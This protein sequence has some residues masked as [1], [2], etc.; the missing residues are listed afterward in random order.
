MKALAKANLKAEERSK[1]TEAVKAERDA[2]QTK[3]RIPWS[4]P[5]R[6]ALLEYIDAVSANRQTLSQSFDRAIDFYKKKMDEG[7]AKEYLDAKRT[8][9]QPRVVA[10]WNYTWLPGKTHRREML[11]DMAFRG[12]EGSW[13]VEKNVVIVKGPDPRLKG[14]HWVDTFETAPDGKTMSGKN[15]LGHKK[16]AKLVEGE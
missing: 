7:K 1:L 3:G 6:A 12:L 5:M 13:K 9:L 2:F 4:A 10:V 15:Q 14:G 8:A 16:S 11:S